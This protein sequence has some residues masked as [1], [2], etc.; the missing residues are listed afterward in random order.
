MFAVFCSGLIA[1]RFHSVLQCVAVCC[2]VLQCVAFCCSALQCVAVCCSG[3]RWVAV[4]CSGLQEKYGLPHLFVSNACILLQCVA[5]CCSGSHVLQGK[6]GLCHLC[7]RTLVLCCT[8][9]QEK[10]DLCLSRT[11]VFCCSVLQRCC[12]VLQCVAAYSSVL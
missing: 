7:S 2:S 11:P 12:S 10:Y 5:V 4:G 6:N 1:V 9:L 3:L 8:T